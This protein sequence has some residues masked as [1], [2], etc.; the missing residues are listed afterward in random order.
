[1][2]TRNDLWL[3]MDPMERTLRLDGIRRQALAAFVAAALPVLVFLGPLPAL[4][5]GGVAATIAHLVAIARV[6]RALLLGHPG[7]AQNPS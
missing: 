6:K 7:I 2:S 5:T 4:L 1:M 3:S